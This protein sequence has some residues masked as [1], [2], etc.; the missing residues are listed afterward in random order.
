MLKL[1]LSL[2]LISL[3]WNCQKGKAVDNTPVGSPFNYSVLQ[4]NGVFAGFEYQ[5]INT[6]PLIKVKFTV[7]LDQ[8]AAKSTIQLTDKS[9]TPIPLNLFFEGKDSTVSISPVSPLNYLSAYTLNFS[10]NL[11]SKLGGFLIIPLSVKLKTAL[12]STNKFPDITTEAL[13]TLVQRQTFKYFWDFGHSI[14]GMARERNTS[15]DI[16][17]SGGSGFGLMAIPVAIQRSFI[18]RTDGLI[19]SQKVVDFLINKAQHFHGAY[20][21]W[22]NGATGAV[23]PFSANDDG[24]DLIETSYLMMGL[25]TIRQYFDGSSSDETAL[26]NDITQLYDAVEWDFFT[27]EGANKLYWHWSPTKNWAMNMP[28]QGWNEGLIAYVLA[29]SSNTHK[30][31]KNVYD[32]GF[33]RN[34]A[35]KNNSIYYGYQLP[36]GEAFGGPLFFEHYSFL[37]I[38]PHGLTDAY[39]DYW[40]QVVNHTKINLAYC[41]LNS[42]K[43]YGYSSRCW[44]LTASDIPNGYTASSPINDVGVIA[45]TA[46]ISSIPYTPAES[47]EALRFFYCQLGDK[48]WGQYGFTDAFNLDMPWFADSFLAIDQGPQIGMIENYRTGLLWHLFM[49]CPEIKTGMTMLGFQS[50]NL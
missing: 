21:H 10:T 20:P 32:N 31:T 45:P 43:Y 16:V 27:R 39:A 2:V 15:G 14:S 30:I 9:A 4:V 35:M 18:S 26:R 50:P 23:I 48:I 3:F 5:G 25:L 44:G 12:D 6:T 19:R 36:L 1:L 49:S 11:K 46:A 28:I 13:L 37:G 42:R 41:S 24:A 8:L 33:A 38:N 7:P 17:T 47:I 22:I 34:G 29:A 40:T